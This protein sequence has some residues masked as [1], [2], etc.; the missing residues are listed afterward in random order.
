MK[1]ITKY[2]IVLILTLYLSFIA[3]YSALYLVS[4]G[5]N[6][7][8][9][10]NEL[11]DFL[12]GV[13]APLAFIFL[14]LGY[15]QQGKAIQNTNENITKQLIQQDELIKLQIAERSERE[16]QSLPNLH[17]KA[18]VDYNSEIYP[19]D[20]SEIRFTIKL[21]NYAEQISNCRLYINSSVVSWN[22]I[23]PKFDE[24][25]KVS[26]YSISYEDWLRKIE[27]KDYIILR[28]SI[29]F[30][31]KLGSRYKIDNEIDVGVCDFKPTS[32]MYRCNPDPIKI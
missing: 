20:K 6:V 14:W 27:G 19:L 23:Y 1:F 24:E 4:D 18:Y 15:Y 13:F 12:A 2:Q 5:V 22:E 29:G 28:V 16:F 3:V 21:A 17:L 30:T 7:Y 25:I 10:S 26:S 11:G 9:S 32:V 31:T 8:L